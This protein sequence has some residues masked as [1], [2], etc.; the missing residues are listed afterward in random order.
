MKT[1]T[2]IIND[3][4]EKSNSEEIYSIDNLKK[5]IDKLEEIIERQEKERNERIAA[6]RKKY[7]EECEKERREIEEYCRK[8]REGTI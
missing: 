1:I 8:I 2:I 6:R 5:E 3:N 4:N 7:Q